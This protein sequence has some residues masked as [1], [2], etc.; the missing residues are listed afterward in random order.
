MLARRGT[1]TTQLYRGE[2]ATRPVL[3][4]LKQRSFMDHPLIDTPLV[5][6]VTPTKDC[7]QK[8]ALRLER[9]DSLREKIKIKKRYYEIDYLKL[10][11][12]YLKLLKI[13]KTDSTLENHKQI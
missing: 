12:D 1:D 13:L 11:I 3:L 8:L 10:L 6:W 4:D 2:L 9:T 5:A 7:V